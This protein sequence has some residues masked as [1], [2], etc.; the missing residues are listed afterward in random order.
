M[1]KKGFAL[2]ELAVVCLISSILLHSIFKLL[3][4]TLSSFSHQEEYVSCTW[5]GSLL[6]SYLQEDLEN[7]FLQNEEEFF[8]QIVTDVMKTDVGFSIPHGDTLV[9]Y[10][11]DSA[12]KIIHRE[13]GGK[14]VKVGQGLV[15]SFSCT[16]RL[17][18]SD[19]TI[20]TID[21]LVAIVET[22]PEFDLRRIWF[23]FKIIFR[24]E[25]KDEKEVL[26]NFSFNGFPVRLNRQ[27]QS[28]WKN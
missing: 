23:E 14:K 28:I 6:S 4:A 10:E 19:G 16:P 2:I 11:F 5:Q 7:A 24:T 8:K 1:K 21:E 3:S 15:K 25:E 13:K 12:Q 20:T 26:H 18:L 17:Q 9:T 22:N 27:L